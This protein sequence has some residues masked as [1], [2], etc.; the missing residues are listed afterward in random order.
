MKRTSPDSSDRLAA[1]RRVVSIVVP[2]L[3]EAES[4]S[5]LLDC[6]AREGEP[7]EIVVSDGG[8]GDGTL[9]V[10]RRRGARIIEGARG[11][12]AQLRAGAAAACGD[13]L[14][15]LHADSRPGPGAVAAIRRSLADPSAVG[16]NFRVVFDGEHGFARRLTEFYAWFRRH[17]LY[18]GDSGIFVRRAAYDRLGGFRSIALMEDYEFS[19]RLNRLGRTV[20]IA[21]PSLTTSARRF[22]GRRPYRIVAGWLAIHALYF[23]RVPPALL[24]RLYKS[25][26]HAPGRRR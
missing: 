4:L 9:D 14:W 21:E 18:Y 1:G 3:D 6:L 23:C 25:R 26:S 8:S 19:R 10:A 11:R 17:G 7:H 13:V 22:E 16:G 20:C 5:R 12:G 2:A 24:A 15:F